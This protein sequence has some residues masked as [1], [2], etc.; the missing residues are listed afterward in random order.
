MSQKRRERDNPDTGNRQQ[1]R[2]KQSE[3][4][5]VED[6]AEDLVT[7]QNRGH[8]DCFFWA[9]FQW[10]SVSLQ[11]TEIR[12]HTNTDLTVF[13]NF[14]LDVADCCRQLDNQEAP[15]WERVWVYISA[16]NPIT[17]HIP[18]QFWVDTGMVGSIVQINCPALV[19]TPQTIVVH[20]GDASAHLRWQT[21][22]RDDHSNDDPSINLSDTRPD[23]VLQHITCFTAKISSQH[24]E[25]MR[26]ANEEDEEMLALIAATVSYNALQGEVGSV[27]QS[28]H[29]KMEKMDKMDPGLSDDPMLHIA[30]AQSSNEYDSHRQIKL[31]QE[32]DY[33]KK[34]FHGAM[35]SHNRSAM[36][37]VNNDLQ[38]LL[39]N[40][41]RHEHGVTN[42]TSPV[43]EQQKV[44]PPDSWWWSWWRRT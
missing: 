10:V 15:R 5:C 7:V 31:K 12:T 43:L 20:D 1:K 23:E 29:D 13:K 18:I 35:L 41:M 2:R 21:F 22:T 42:D 34:L 4:G 14:I 39:D 27:L 38:K 33:L 24:W 40:E 37:T 28:L 11:Q 8:G 16:W 36:Q 9:L 44:V 19:K 6:F 32:N 17:Q 26:V 25:W 3:K 30:I